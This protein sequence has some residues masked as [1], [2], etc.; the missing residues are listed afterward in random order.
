MTLVSSLNDR[1]DRGVIKWRGNTGDSEFRQLVGEDRSRLGKYNLEV[2]A[3]YSHS[4]VQNK[5]KMSL[6]I[7]TAGFF[8]LSPSL[9]AE[10]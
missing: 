6:A 3:I 2:L 9:T 8:P 5:L 4:N 1:D 10:M 7:Q